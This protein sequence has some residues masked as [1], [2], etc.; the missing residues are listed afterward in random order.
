MVQKT[1]WTIGALNDLHNI[2]EYIARDSSRY[3]QLQ[4]ENIQ[5]AVLKLTNFP[6][7]GHKVPELLHLPYREILVGNYRILY[8]FD[9]K[10]DQIIIMAVVHVR[11]MLR[12]INI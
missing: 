5:N 2:Y 3:A 9:E 7:S 8:K 10:D 1:E 11:R 12:D 6:L 4:I